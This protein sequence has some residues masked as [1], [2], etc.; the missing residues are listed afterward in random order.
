MSTRAAAAP[1]RR[2][3][4]GIV[5]GLVT[6]ERMA[7]Y[8]GA[9][10]GDVERA[11]ARYEWNIEASAGVMGLSS[12]VEVVVR[13]AID[14]ELTTWARRAHGPHAEWFDHAPLDLKGRRD[15]KVVAELSFGFW[16]YLLESR[17]HTALWVP[18]LHRA[19]PDGARDLRQRRAH[20]AHQMQQLQFVRNRAAHH[21]PIHC[22][23][24]GKDLLAA[25]TLLQ[26]VSAD[27]V[28]WMTAVCPVREIIGRRPR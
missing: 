5:L 11:F 14:R 2:W 28:A 25:E 15:G 13:N 8:L 24:L 19:F 18:A 21:E 1:D 17:Y 26:H 16:R 23:D 12:V 27:A 3:D 7:S 6:P 20:V 10:Q 4:Y 9:S 22:R